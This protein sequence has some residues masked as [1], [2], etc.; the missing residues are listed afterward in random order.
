MNNKQKI[1][2][3]EVNYY[4]QQRS[5]SNN[6]KTIKVRIVAELHE[7]SLIKPFE[8]HKT[9]CFQKIFFMETCQQWL[10]K[11]KEDLHELSPFEMAVVI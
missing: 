3:R 10:S 6:K 5:S 2:Q 8:R 9:R 1:L 11:K 4:F 7:V